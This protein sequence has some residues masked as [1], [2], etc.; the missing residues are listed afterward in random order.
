VVDADPVGGS[1]ATGWLG[2]GLAY[3]DRSVVSF[4][5]E[6]AAAGIS[7]PARLDQHLQQVPGIPNC[8]LMAGPADPTQLRFVASAGW[9]RLAT[10]L[11]ELS[12][13]G[14]DVLVDCGRFGSGTPMALLTAA[15]LVLIAVR[16]KA[17]DWGAARCLAGQLRSVIDPDRLGLA[18]CATTPLGTM[19]AE[20]YLGLYAIVALPSNRRVAMAFSDG[21]RRPV[22]FRRSRLVRTAARTASLLHV[23]VNAR[24][25][26]VPAPV[27]TAKV[28]SGHQYESKSSG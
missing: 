16:P 2:G 27:G 26:T 5:I 7:G 3:P 14:H 18:V 20:Q 23:V 8:M 6:T 11:S 24:H 15:D 4:A 9:H 25:P 1:L 19:A 21:V 13:S 10:A 12:R 28:F 17:W 22:G